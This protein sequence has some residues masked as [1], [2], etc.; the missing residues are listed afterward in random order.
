MW[1]V[2][3]TCF[4][5]LVVLMS[6]YVFTDV[7]FFRQKKSTRIFVGDRDFFHELSEPSFMRSCISGEFFQVFLDLF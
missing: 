6:L 3:A 5:H 2:F 7:F 4:E 1:E